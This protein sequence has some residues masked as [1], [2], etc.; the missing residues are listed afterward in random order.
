MESIIKT[1]VFPV[2]DNH[3]HHLIYDARS[4]LQSRLLAG[5]PENGHYCRAALRRGETCPMFRG[6]KFFRRGRTTIGDA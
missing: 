4:G 1:V 3:K 6:R 5:R 2:P